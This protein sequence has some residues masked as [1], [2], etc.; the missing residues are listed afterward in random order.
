MSETVFSKEFRIRY[1]ETGPDGI[2]KIGAVF[3]YLQ[4]VAGGHAALLGVSSADLMERNLGWV[5]HQYRLE[6]DRYPGSNEAIRIATWR[7]SHRRLYELREFEV[8]DETGQTLVHAKSCWI[9]INLKSRKPLRLDRNLPAMEGEREVDWDF[10]AP[11]PPDRID[12]KIT[13]PVRRHDLDINRHANNAVFVQWALDT[14]SPETADS[15]SPHRVDALFT[16]EALEGDNLSSRTQRID[17]SDDPVFL[18]AI[19]HAETGKELSRIKSCWRRRH[20]RNR[21]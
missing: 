14:V 2:L 8:E 9:L 6:A 17:N 18:H 1:S 11:E 3:N 19:V 15:F 21:K 12:R 10:A 5:L 7:H 20:P 4:D 16:A 13:F